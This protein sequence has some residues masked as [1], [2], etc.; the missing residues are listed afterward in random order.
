MQVK[1]AHDPFT[2]PRDRFWAQP[3]FFAYFIV[4]QSLT[5]HFQNAAFKF[6]ERFETNAI[7]ISRFIRRR[8]FLC[9]LLC[10]SARN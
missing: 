10:S 8:C 2:V 1:F 3:E 5:H 4:I 9:W 6:A 7:P